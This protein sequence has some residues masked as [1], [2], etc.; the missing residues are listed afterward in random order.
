MT[1]STLDVMSFT[2]QLKAVAA[3]KI[4]APSRCTGNFHSSAT[5]RTSSITDKGT[6]LPKEWAFSRQI[7]EVG[8]M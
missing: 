8:G 1:E 5:F 4:L 3:L 7:R 2:S 6:D